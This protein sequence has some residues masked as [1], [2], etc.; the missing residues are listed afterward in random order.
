MYPALRPR[1]VVVMDN[2]NS[3]KGRLVRDVIRKAGAH[4]FFLPAYSPDMNDIAHQ[5]FDLALI[6]ALARPTKAIVKQ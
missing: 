1:D 3:L 4:L 2:L 5:A 6:I